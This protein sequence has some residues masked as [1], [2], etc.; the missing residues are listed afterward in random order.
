METQEKCCGQ[1]HTKWTSGWGVWKYIGFGILGAIGFTLLAFLFGFVIMKLWNVL[2]P[3]IFHLTTITYWQ[4][5]GLAI[6]GR[7]LI[8]G[9]HPGGHH[10]KADHKF[11]SHVGINC[12]CGG[13]KWSQY[14]KYWQEEGEKSFDEY[15][16]RKSELK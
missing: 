16:K 5:V 14:D 15:V 4:A 13:E 9:V 8:G 7:L 12:G 10:K 3:E 6:L 11:H 1:I 2:M